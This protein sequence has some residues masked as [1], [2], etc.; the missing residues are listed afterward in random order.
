MYKDIFLNAGLNE[1]EAEVYNYLLSNGRCPASEIIKNTPLKRGVV[2]LTLDSLVEKEFIT[3][4]MMEPE[5]SKV[6]NKKRIA[7]FFP[8]HP[9]SIRRSLEIEEQEIKKARN[10]L[11]ANMQDIISTFNMV[12][13]KPGVR[14]FEGD[15]GI[16]SVIYDTFTSKETIYTYADIETINKYIKKINEE[17]ARERDKRK[18]NK[19]IIFSDTP[20]SK[21]YLKTY[22]LKTT[23][24]RIV[25]GLA[26]FYTV[27]QI[28]S[29]KV[30]YI[31]LSDKTKIGVIIEN[32]EIYQTHRSLF[33]QQW[34]NAL[35]VDQLPDKDSKHK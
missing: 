11:E 4:K 9:E 32:A 10:N 19:K 30:S 7:F 5:N 25:P 20:Y 14:Y 1:N 17:Y 27:M 18:L 13:G 33:K 6:R 15:D 34:K 2:Y 12:S 31:T 22:H 8:E 16:K 28:Y 23:D 26:N 21:N 3:E 35:P 24:S 29:N